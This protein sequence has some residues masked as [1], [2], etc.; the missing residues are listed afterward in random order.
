MGIEKDDIDKFMKENGYDI[1][2]D[3]IEII[4]E[5]MDKNRDS[6][7]DYSEFIDEIKSMNFC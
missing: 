5:K 2:E 7:I 3:E 1:K 6:Q 4:F